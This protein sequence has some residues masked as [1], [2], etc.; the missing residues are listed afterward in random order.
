MGCCGRCTAL[1]LMNQLWTAFATLQGKLAA[2]GGRRQLREWLEDVGVHVL[3]SKEIPVL[4][5]VTNSNCWWILPAIP[6]PQACCRQHPASAWPSSWSKLGRVDGISRLDWFLMSLMGFHDTPWPSLF[7][8]F[9]KLVVFCGSSWAWGFCV[10]VS[11]SGLFQGQL[12]WHLCLFLAP[13][14]GD[15]FGRLF[16]WAW[17][18]PAS[19]LAAAKGSANI[20]WEDTADI[21]PSGVSSLWCLLVGRENFVNKNYSLV[22]QESSS[23]TLI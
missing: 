7:Q 21:R 12:F 4:C 10:C 19:C 13:R 2:R 9:W 5:G 11:N 23:P 6:C 8:L 20:F 1:L 22:R 14:R 15:F 16:V 18:L 17:I 3:D